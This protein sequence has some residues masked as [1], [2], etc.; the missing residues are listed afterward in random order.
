[1]TTYILTNFRIHNSYPIENIMQ[2]GGSSLGCDAG[3]SLIAF[4]N[5]I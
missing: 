3:C 4:D 2:H 1:M 5:N